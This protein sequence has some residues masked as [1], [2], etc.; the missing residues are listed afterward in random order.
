M[1]FT[2]LN[3]AGACLIDVEAHTDE[4]GF[5]ARTFCKEELEQLG[6]IANIA[7]CSTSFNARRG[8]LRG[9]H[10]QIAPHE[11]TKIVRCTSGAIFDVIVDVRPESTTFGTWLAAELTARNR[12]MMYVPEGVA[13]GFQTLEDGSEVFYQISTG[14]SSEASRG[15]RWDDPHLAIPWPIPDDKI[16]SPRDSQ[17]PWLSM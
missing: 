11:E 13:H 10:Y 7:Q 5:F 16:I 8:T 9:L 6:L 1:K 4:R 17:F 15:I 2:Q 12:R 3:I 14:F